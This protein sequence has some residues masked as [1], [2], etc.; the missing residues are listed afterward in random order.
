MRR[1]P[2]CLKS[3]SSTVSYEA[4]RFCISI[5]MV[6]IYA[7][8]Q[9]GV[10]ASDDVSRN[11]LFSKIDNHGDTRIR[12]IIRLDD[13]RTAFATVDG[14]DIFD[15]SRFSHLFNVTSDKYPLRGYDGYHH[16]YLSHGGKYLWLKNMHSLQCVDLDTE[17]FATDVKGVLH[18]LGVDA[19]AD[20]FFAD[21]LGRIWIVAGDDL[22]LPQCKKNFSIDNHYGGL[23]DLAADEDSA[24]LFYRNGIVSRL[25]IK[26]G[27]IVYSVAA[28][29]ESKH[30]KYE[31][32]S[33]LAESSDG[34]YQIRNG[35]VGAL[36]HFNVKS[37]SWEKLL[38]SDIRL[39]TIAVSDS[40]IF[41]STPNGLI[42]YN[43]SDLSFEHIPYLRTKNGNLLASELSTIAVDNN[44]GILVGTLNRGIFYHNPLL[45]RYHSIPKGTPSPL[46]TPAVSSVF[47]ENIDGSVNINLNGKFANVT[48][49]DSLRYGIEIAY[50]DSTP[51]T[52]SGEYG[53][54]A[55]FVSGNGAIFFNE[56]DRLSIF[57]PNDS[58]S[59]TNSRTP[60]ISGILVNAR[61]IEPL[62]SYDGEVVTTKIAARSEAISLPHYG[63]FI[64]FEVSDPDISSANP[65]FVF[66]L[67]G[68]DKDWRYATPSDIRNRMLTT[69]Y[70]ALAPGKYRF[71]V[72]KSDLP[73]S[74]EASIDVVIRH[75]WWASP[76][77]FAIYVLI[78]IIIVITGIR[79]YVAREKRRIETEQKEKFLL[80]RIRQ[81][82]E[83]TDR[84]KSEAPA[85]PTDSDGDNQSVT[86]ESEL[87]DEDR[88][89]V[90]R[91]I[92]TVERNLDT[93][94]YSVA[95]L[96]ADLC[97]DRTG[98]YRKLTSLLDKSPSIFIRDIRLRKAAALISE[99]KMSIT[100]IADATGFSSTSYMSKCFQEH[101]GCKPSEYHN[102]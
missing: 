15:G 6:C 33:L 42:L 80:E 30:F 78:A 1:H 12:S 11:F 27:K 7:V 40:G 16:L 83:E 76:I 77:A 86:G 2:Q 18:G 94:G 88:D 54:G 13:G 67:E 32:T 45:Y 101:Y 73:D 65:K 100:E 89:F 75:P 26:S 64:T 98:L 53:S 62:R 14:I 95:R 66:M 81:L 52:M 48:F 37:A 92:E 59:I 38:E 61:R 10:A 17:I 97:M 41:I 49:P 34:F 102:K 70:T 50:T 56:T 22:L 39:N 29:P 79:I 51:I 47:S 20:D 21:K 60:F 96:S 43:P 84:Y 35:A 72:K 87:S 4:V 23:I 5:I 91:A 3:V 82:I 58:A 74:P 25:D 85:S 93:P 71:R 55:S 46:S 99:G 31:F 28:Y 63:N 36:F 68:A 19:P 69:T 8:I 57:V 9:C 90:T 24:Y 44:N